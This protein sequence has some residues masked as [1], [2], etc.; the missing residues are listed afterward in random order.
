MDSGSILRCAAGVKQVIGSEIDYIEGMNVA[1]SVA[2]A[3]AALAMLVVIGPGRS[4]TVAEGVD[5]LP[6]EALHGWTRIPIPA[7]AGVNQKLQWRVDARDHTLI[8]AGDGG[9]EWLRYD[10]ELGDFVLAVDWRFTPR[11]E[12]ETRYNSG[13]G[14]RLSKFGEIWTQAQT[15]QA[16]A[17]LFGANFTEGAIKSFNLSKQMTDNR[18][19]PVGQWNHFEIRAEGEKITLTVNGAVVNELTGVGLRRGYIGL[20]AEGYEVTFRELRLKELK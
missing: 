3:V 19:R 9:H 13:V 14:V 8:C 20:E 15:G 11:T 7:I 4:G 12:G 18:V 1:R 17:Y 6:D 16:G 5:I 10:R 2:G